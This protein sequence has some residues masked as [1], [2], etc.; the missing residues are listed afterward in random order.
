ML[1]RSSTRFAA[2]AGGRLSAPRPAE[3]LTLDEIG[4]MLAGMD[5]AKAA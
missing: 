3:G 5:G 1:F 4:L 2:L